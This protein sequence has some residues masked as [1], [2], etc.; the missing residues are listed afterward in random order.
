MIEW[1]DLKRADFGKNY[2]HSL[3]LYYAV[4]GGWKMVPSMET[5][6]LDT[7]YI[8]EYWTSEIKIV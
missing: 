8:I 4:L 7:L 3:C 5:H 2:W 6:F 1:H